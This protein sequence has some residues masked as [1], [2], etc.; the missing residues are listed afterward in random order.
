MK[1]IRRVRLIWVLLK[2]LLTIHIILIF[3]AGYQRNTGKGVLYL[4]LHNFFLERVYAH[5]I[6]AFKEEN[7]T[8]L[9]KYNPEFLANLTEY[10]VW[11]VSLDRV[12]LTFTEPIVSQNLIYMFDHDYPNSKFN[13]R[14]KISD[15]V[16]SEEA[17]RH[18]DK[19]LPFPMI[20]RLY[21]EGLHKEI[22]SLRFF[23]K[24]LKVF[25][26][27]NFNRDQYDNP[28]F[29]KYFNK[30]SRIALLE[31]I[32][33]N[34]TSDEIILTNDLTEAISDVYI[35]KI[36]ISAWSRISLNQKSIKG[37]IENK[38]W[39]KTLSGA[40]FLLACPGFVQPMCHNLIEAMS[41]GVVPILEH[42]E[43]LN[44]PLEHKVNAIIF[45]GASDL[46]E[47]LREVL[48][49]DPIQIRSMQQNV[50]SYY[51]Q[52]L[53]LAAACRLLVTSAQKRDTVF[54]ITSNLFV[55]KLNR[56]SII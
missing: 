15:E 25:F 49:M 44:P 20:P 9:I 26:S 23:Q 53:S 30:L 16:L 11:I 47:K 3:K 28:I 8:I 27:G 43:F 42:P 46:C 55:K 2:N 19:F 21:Y 31:A 33:D 56:F 22:H 10:G 24:K 5:L 12:Q 39:L 36:V 52:H 34:L 54:I 29:E 7:Y 48:M 35:N 17:R 37:R 13:F 6:Y 1:F 40:D 51:D 50:I 38:D 45:S 4:D 18:P 41:V 32:K 14:V